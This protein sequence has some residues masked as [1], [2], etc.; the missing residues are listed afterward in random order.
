[1]RQTEDADLRL[2][3]IA[4]TEPSNKKAD[5]CCA[6]P[7]AVRRSCL[8]LSSQGRDEPN[9]Q[10]IVMQNNTASTQAAEPVALTTAELDDINGGFG[11]LLAAAVI[12]AIYVYDAYQIY[13]AAK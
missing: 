9:T 2:A 8:I 7:H 11:L 5:L 4:G 1:M 3:P 12:G 6:A 13:K 10:E